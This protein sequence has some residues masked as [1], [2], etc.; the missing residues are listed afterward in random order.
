MT[1]EQEAENIE[2]LKAY[3][4]GEPVEYW[5]GERDPV[6]WYKTSNVVAIDRIVYRRKPK[7]ELAPWTM[8]DVPL[9]CWFKD[10]NKNV[11]FPCG[12]IDDH[13]VIVTGFGSVYFD[14][15][16]VIWEHSTDRVN[17][18]PCGKENP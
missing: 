17:W 3:W 15:L 10:K 7:P 6:G 1:P 11:H 8:D 4:R 13:S 18:L 16:L 5:S 9:N 14:R 2:V 12:P